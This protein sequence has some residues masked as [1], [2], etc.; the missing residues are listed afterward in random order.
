MRS[1]ASPRRLRG[2]RRRRPLVVHV[3]GVRP[4]YMKIAPVYQELGHNGRV[5]QK[6]IHTG[7]H[8]DTSVKDVFFGELSLPKPHF[9]LSVG[10]GSHGAQ[11]ARALEG[12]E[13]LFLELG[14][15]LVVVPGDV[16]SS[17]AAA[18]AAAKL[19]IPVCHVEAGLRSYDTSMPEEHNRR[20]I[21][22]LSS[23]LLTHSL[24]ANDNLAHEGIAGGVVSFVG[25]TMIDTLLANAV[26][27]RELAAWDEYGVQRGNYI[28]VTL[29]RPALV[30][31]P[32]LLQRTMRNLAR[33]ARELPVVFPVHPRTL[34]RLAWSSA[35]GSSG[36]LLVP[37]LSYRRFVSLEMG[38]AAVVTDSGGVQEET[39]ALGVPCFTLRENTERP[40]TVSHGTNT[41][42][43]LDPRRL[44][45]IPA[46]LRESPPPLCPPLWDGGAGVRAA[47]EI[48]LALG[49]DVAVRE[50]AHVGAGMSAAVSVA[51]SPEL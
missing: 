37:P 19:Q 34:A 33:L 29:H 50:A 10:S 16:N 42:L 44:L 24:E 27:A 35:R 7:Q 28:L 30:D 41:I 32:L 17:L 5:R 20:L 2:S 3:V 13:R 38:A 39:T 31:S 48:E 22:H 45:D 26:R 21:D 43:G 6:L 8:Y 36:L 9:E 14:P 46:L 4:N 47:S 11:T 1:A 49:A 25:N 18:L 12:L 23:L 15:D 51:R 40:V